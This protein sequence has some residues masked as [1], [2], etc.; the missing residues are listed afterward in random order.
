[1]A[2]DIRSPDNRLSI[3]GEMFP[4][5][6]VTKRSKHALDFKL[7]DNCP[8]DQPLRWIARDFGH[9]LVRDDGIVAHGKGCDSNRVPDLGYP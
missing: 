9:Q 5:C 8:L 3:R 6:S 7:H 2:K 1:M 4:K